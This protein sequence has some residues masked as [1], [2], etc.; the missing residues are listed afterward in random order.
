MDAGQSNSPERDEL[1]VNLFLA[2]MSHPEPG[3][4]AFMRDAC[5]GDE[6]LLSLV[7][8]RVDWEGRLNGFLLKPLVARDR[9]DHPFTPGQLVGNRFRIVRVAGEGGM[10]VVYEAFDEKLRHRMALKCPRLEFR[11]RLSPEALKSLLVTDVNVCRVFEIHTEMTPRGEIDFITMEYVEGETLSARL[12]HAPLRWL[13]TAEGSEIARQIC[14][15]ISAIHA[16]GIIHRDLKSGNVMLSTSAGSVRAVIMDFGIA[17]AADVFSSEARGTPS[18]LAPEIWKGAPATVQSD[19]YA[20]GVLLWEMA[21]QRLPFAEN[22]EWTDRLV[23]PPAPSG[24]REPLRTLLQCCLDANP[25]RRP[26]SVGEVA[27][28]LETGH[29]R[30]WFAGLAAGAVTC[31]A[32]GALL[33]SVRG[34]PETARFS[35]RP[36]T[37]FPGGEYEPAFSANADRIAFVWEGAREGKFDIYVQPVTGTGLLRITSAQGSHGSPAWSPDGSEIAFVRY[38]VPEDESGVYIAGSSGGQERKL[39]GMQPVHE[40]Y[41]RHLDWSPSGDLLALADR[42]SSEEPFSIYSVSARDGSRVR[43]TNPPANSRGDTGPAFSP[44][45][46]SLVFRR[47][48]SSS[49]N[50][51]YIVSTAG[52]PARRLTTDNRFSSAS[53]WTPSGREIIFSSN[54]AGRL[55]LWRV[56]AAGGVPALI[57]N[58]GEGA[59]FLSIAKRGSLLAYSQWY[60][61][62]NVWRYSL[63]GSGE[64]P[65]AL[66]SSTREDINPH[67]SP[68]S[69][70]IAFRSTRSGQNEIWT[71]DA[72]GGNPR[73]LTSSGGSLTGTPRWS[74]DGRHIAYD[75]RPSGASQIY[76]IPAT[77]GPPVRVTSAGDNVTPSWS[78]DGKWIYLASNRSGTWQIWRTP[79]DMQDGDGKAQQLTRNGGFVPFESPDGG[80]VYHARGLSS[81]G[82]FRTEIASGREDVVV[83]DLEPGFW[84]QWALSR[85]YLY[86]VRMDENRR[87]SLY[88]RE[89]ASGET[90]SVALLLKLPIK[91]ENGLSVSMDDRWALYVQGDQSGSDIMLVE[92]FR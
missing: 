75:S 26:R 36:F 38:A 80:S 58:T 11:K 22:A 17:H 66:I 88:R 39:T 9:L 56:A 30:R 47:T 51:L 20:L 19:I 68:D 25:D 29:S 70:R 73:I 35:T 14:S 7:R 65:V 67:Y 44:D 28:A 33:W 21:C 60:S 91:D 16:A 43:L 2:A 77:G 78:A 15:G 5:E 37:S 18:Y 12:P 72:D 27:A 45:G 63:S 85:R 64:A 8:R 52:G 49:V 46:R 40:L 71:A 53:A 48:V 62:T 87:A 59:N 79:A 6:G 34:K 57:P 23:A 82:L 50:D 83:P 41:D 69:T 54:R 4:D 31:G 3:R 24:I 32:A 74:A 84:G 86:W 81:A 92:G 13:A 10:G 61:D 1:V 90:R 76:V 42:S 89:L 55:Q